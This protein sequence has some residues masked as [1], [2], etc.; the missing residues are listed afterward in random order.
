MIRCTLLHCLAVQ[1][2]SETVPAAAIPASDPLVPEEPATKKQKLDVAVTSTAP[3]VE[4]APASSGVDAAAP[5]VEQ[6]AYA[7]VL[8]AGVDTPEEL[9]LTK[10]E[11][12]ELRIENTRNFLVVSRTISC[13]TFRP[14]Y[15]QVT[16][17]MYEHHMLP[18]KVYTGIFSTKVYEANFQP[19][20]ANISIGSVVK[21]IVDENKHVHI[22]ALASPEE[23]QVARK[24]IDFTPI[25]DAPTPPKDRQQLLARIQVLEEERNQLSKL[26]MAAY[27]RKTHDQ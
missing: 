26:I 7:S 18:A 10:L 17:C 19:V 27:T 6:G 22:V 5:S 3:K 23:T 14:G 11:T 9:D 25:A 4:D 24:Y 20:L 21:C 1:M 13:V 8:M 12:R 2:A 15:K 16:L